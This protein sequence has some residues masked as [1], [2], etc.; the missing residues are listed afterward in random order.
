MEDPGTPTRDH[1]DSEEFEHPKDA[2][3]DQQGETA[4]PAADEPTDGVR[5][6]R[7]PAADDT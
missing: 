5:S 1:H 7:E 3:S 4:P 2:V 6:G